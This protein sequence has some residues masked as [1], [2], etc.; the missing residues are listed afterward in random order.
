MKN[1][2]KLT[3]QKGDVIAIFMVTALAVCVGAAFFPLS[4]ESGEGVVQIWQEGA[5]MKSLPL[6]ENCRF[7]I[8]GEYRNVVEI[9][10]GY[11]GIAESDC[12]GE[13]CVHSG[14]ISTAGRSII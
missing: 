5:L 14:W 8:D 3:F 13:D 11:A 2:L 12:P 1:K 4:G 10:D 6:D 9:R 7:E